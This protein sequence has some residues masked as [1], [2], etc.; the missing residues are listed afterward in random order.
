[1]RKLFVILL[2]I[3][4]VGGWMACNNKGAKQDQSAENKGNKISQ[5]E[6][7]KSLTELNDLK[8][9]FDA[10]ETKKDKDDLMNQLSGKVQLLLSKAPNNPDANALMDD[11]QMYYAMEWARQ[12]KY[13]KAIEIVDNVLQ[14]S[15]N[16]EKAKSMKA[17]FEDWQFLTHDEFKKIK[18]HMY[19]DE[20]I[21]LVGYP[22]RK[23][24]KKD[25]FKRTVHGWFYKEPSM[26]KA[27]AIWFDANGQIWAKK[28]PKGTKEMKTAESGK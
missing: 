3:M 13:K 20:V 17:Q 25:K 7:N 9:K 21:Q 11:V 12:G 14:F 4:S 1:M 5:E 27:I 10:A 28:W 24:T 16:N 23:E 26:N 15:P 8:A 6:L 18:K 2:L 19:M 22:V